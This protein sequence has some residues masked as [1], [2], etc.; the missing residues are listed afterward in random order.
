METSDALKMVG[1]MND[2]VRDTFVLQA[3]VLPPCE[4]VPSPPPTF[5]QTLGF[6]SSA[7]FGK[8]IRMQVAHIRGEPNPMNRHFFSGRLPS[9]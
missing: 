8:H 1:H 6:D 2:W 5:S 7:N 9:L 3:A 4:S